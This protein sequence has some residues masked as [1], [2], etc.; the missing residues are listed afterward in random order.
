MA[1]SDN[2]NRA[3]E[4]PL[5]GN[6]TTVGGAG[7]NMQL[8]SNQVRAAVTGNHSCA[9]WNTD[10][11]SADHFAEIR[12]TAAAEDAGPTVRNLKTDVTLY[13]YNALDT[14]GAIA[15]L[16]AGTYTN[17]AVRAA[18]WAAGDLCRLIVNG[19]T[20][21][22]KKN[23]VQIGADLTDS[24]IPGNLAAGL[25]DFGSAF[26][27]IDDFLADVLVQPPVRGGLLTMGVG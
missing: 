6:W 22:A 16:I 17:L 20:L 7:A 5:A 27:D 9:Y 21:Q 23:G 11:G 26:N 13:T 24:S 25:C 4:N 15:K 8:L 1:F 14:G 3:N 12:Y 18:T 2:F 10:L 19:S